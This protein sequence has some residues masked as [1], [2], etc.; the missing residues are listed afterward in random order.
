MVFFLFRYFGNL[1]RHTNGCLEPQRPR[2]NN[3]SRAVSTKVKDEIYMSLN[4]RVASLSPASYVILLYYTPL[5]K[6]VY[7]GSLLFRNCD[8]FSSPKSNT[9]ISWLICVMSSLFS[10]V[11]LALGAVPT[12]LLRRPQDSMESL[13]HSHTACE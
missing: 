10:D 3:C 11:S 4:A 2:Y 5:L 1:P 7:C 6:S 8:C 12:D 13:P 9:N